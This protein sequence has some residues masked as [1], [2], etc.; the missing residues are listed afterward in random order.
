MLERPEAGGCVGRKYGGGAWGGYALYLF[1]T[2]AERDAFVVS[3]NCNRAIEP[4]ITI[5]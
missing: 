5:R 2:P 4:Y 1:A 3:A